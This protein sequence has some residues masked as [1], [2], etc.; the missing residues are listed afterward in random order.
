[1]VPPGPSSLSVCR[2][3]GV[4]QPDEAGTLERSHVV[5]GPALAQLVAYLDMPT[6]QVIPAG[7]GYN[8]P[9]SQGRVDLLQF[10]YPS[11]PGVTVTVDT[12]GCRSASN[13]VRTVAGD[14]IGAH[15]ARW[16]G[17]DR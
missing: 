8:C 11:G 3:A 4:N 13:G 5:T 17:T 6:W 9:L 15:L 10:D 2:Y 7:A 16:V 12:D 1:M 14:E